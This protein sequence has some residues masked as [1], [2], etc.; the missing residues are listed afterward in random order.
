V[1]NDLQLQAPTD[2]KKFEDF[3]WGMAGEYVDETE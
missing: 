2:A 3:L 1:E